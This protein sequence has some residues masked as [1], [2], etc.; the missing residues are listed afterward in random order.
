M[1]SSVV[2]KA[3]MPVEWTIEGMTIGRSSAGARSAAA[4]ARRRDVDLLVGELG[5]RA[6]EEAQVHALR[7]PRR[8]REDQVEAVGIVRLDAG[9]DERRL[10]LPRARAGA[11]DGDLGA[12]AR[13][14]VAGAWEA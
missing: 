12:V 11:V 13:R 9:D 2:K 6:V 8:L 5:A 1:S 4:G 14:D 3:L 10:P 7:R